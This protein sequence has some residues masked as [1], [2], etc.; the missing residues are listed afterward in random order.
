LDLRPIGPLIPKNKKG[1]NIFAHYNQSFFGDEF[2]TLGDP[3]KNKNYHRFIV[4]L[5]KNASNFGFKNIFKAFIIT[6]LL[7][8]QFSRRLL[9]LRTKSILGCLLQN[10]IMSKK[11]KKNLDNNKFFI[12]EKIQNPKKA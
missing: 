5:E 11:L 12:R 6:F 3:P 2:S 9:P 4:F 7:F 8:G 1:L 10:V